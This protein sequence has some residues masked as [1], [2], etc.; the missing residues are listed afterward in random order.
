V[1][2]GDLDV[3]ETGGFQAGVVLG[4]GECSGDAANT[5]AAFGS[6]VGREVVVSEGA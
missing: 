4:E 1:G 2:G 5:V 3:G 6:L